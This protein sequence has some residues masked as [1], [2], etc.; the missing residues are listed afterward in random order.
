[1]ATNLPFSVVRDACHET[2]VRVILIGGQALGSRGYQRMT[3]DVDFMI[4]D[5]DYDRLMN[6]VCARGFREAV[7]T[8]VA[9]KLPAE[10]GCFVDIDFLFVDAKTFEGVYGDATEE[11]YKEAKFLVPKVEHLIA[12]KLHAIKQ[13]PRSR[14]L[15][16]LAD[17]VELIR[18][19]KIDVCRDAF[20]SMCLKFG[21]PE[22]YHKI[23]MHGESDG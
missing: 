11:D 1:M 4:V 23:R 13:Q 7:R 17:V 21:T 14:E 3:L 22:L 9:A 20:K 2:G 12:L 19:N 8:H 10:S 6:A 5:T 15:K 16:D 18:A